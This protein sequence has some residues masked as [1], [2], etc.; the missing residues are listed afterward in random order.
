MNRAD[1]KD[2][3]NNQPT[4]WLVDGSGY[5]FRAFYAI[6]TRLT[7]NGTPVNAVFGFTGMLLKLEQRLREQDSLAVVF[8]AGR[9]TF[10]NEI[11]PEYK[12]NR[13]ETPPELIPQFALTHEA[14]RALGF[15][16]LMRE[17]FEADDIIAAYA[18]EAR[19]KGQEV[20]I[21][22]SDKDLMQLVRPGVSLW[23]PMKEKSV[24]AG[25]VFE[26]FGVPPEKVIDVQSLAGDSSDNIPGVP[27]IGVKTAAQLINEYGDLDSLLAGAAQ[28][29]Q[30]KRRESLQTFAEQARISRQLV[31]LRDDAELP[32]P[33][34]EL[35]TRSRD[36]KRLREFLQK[37]EF[38]SLLARLEREGRLE[39]TA[40]AP[41][42]ADTAG[43][44][45][46]K[47]AP[48]GYHLI[49]SL[50]TLGEWLARARLDGLLAID[51]ETSSLDAEEAR[52]VGISL[53][54]RDGRAGY[55]PLAHRARGGDLLDTATAKTKTKTAAGKSKAK[56]KKGAA[57][58]GADTDGVLLPEQPATDDVLALLA[59]V[60]ADEAV[61]KIGQNIKYDIRVLARLGVS[62][63]GFDDTM[64]LSYVLDGGRGGHGMDELARRHLERDTMT[65][66]EATRPESGRGALPFAEVSL[67]RARDYA[68]EDA[69]VTLA[70]WRVLRPRLAGEGMVSVYETLERPLVAVLAQ[71]EANGILL[72]RA[73]LERLDRDF[74]KGA[75]ALAEECHRL[76]GHSFNLAS[77]KQLGE[78]LFDEL[79]LPANPRRGKSGARSTQHEILEDL[80][81]RGYELPERVLEWRALAKLRST[82]TEALLER[83]NPASGR[84]HTHFN[85]SG[86]ST[87][88]L[89]SSNPNLQNIPIRSAEGRRIRGAF[90]AAEGWKLLS[91]DYSQIELRLAAEMIGEEGLRAAFREGRDIH[92]ATAAEIFHLS[93]DEVTSERRREAKA[94]NFGILYGMSP[95]GLARGLKISQAE[96][97]DFMERYF[98]RYPDIRRWMDETRVRARE[99]GM[100]ETAFGRRIYL[101]S[102]RSRNVAERRF[103]ERAAINAPIQG[104]AADIIRR[105]MIRLPGALEG[106]GLGA[107]LLLQVHDELVLEVPED[108]VDVTSDLVRGVME[109]APE[110]VFSFSPPLA[111]EAGVGDNWDEAH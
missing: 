37:H 78:V 8:D 103:G 59:P 41:P 10:R 43:I 17:G 111:A 86:A 77:P 83:I 62:V 35:R 88:R 84:V 79:G 40:A 36:P 99:T 39:T 97:R 106:A 26:K 13:D 27:G 109:S 82:Y 69:E 70:L 107:R 54:L 102:V 20:V 6:P 16:V 38:R 31:T 108:E 94:I 22:S 44:K 28:I 90:H 93:P 56:T 4:L 96:A 58:N 71:M 47:D 66:A 33:L 46:D 52:L 65:Y 18:R 11:Y 9:E 64:L 49:T 12:A 89:A 105:A 3:E 24:G 42:S 1:N 15:P 60:L 32:A 104:T 101:P 19:D 25:E 63:R 74:A 53:A 92:A 98:A 5:I 91:V 67:A 50:E 57:K 85:Q 21:V 110:P 30:P 23:E 29:K 61:L 45:D 14:T 48:R 51:T 100:V 80:A 7:A 2:S 75:A 34:D 68:A 72:R 95:F 87:G 73:T 76:A 55:I 81:A